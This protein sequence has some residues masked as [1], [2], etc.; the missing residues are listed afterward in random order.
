M[1]KIRET[2]QL[3]RRGYASMGI[4]YAPPRLGTAA[5]VARLTGRGADSVHALGDFAVASYPRRQ[6][7]QAGR[8]YSLAD[9]QQGN[10]RNRPDCRSE[11][12]TTEIQSPMYL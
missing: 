4:A 11:E 2:W 8:V 3:A 7:H 9:H 10:N 5:P 12:H 1:G 6:P